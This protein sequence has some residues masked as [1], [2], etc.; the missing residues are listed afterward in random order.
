MK[1]KFHTAQS[2]HGKISRAIRPLHPCAAEYPHVG[3][4]SRER[5]KH[6]SWAGAISGGGRERPH[7]VCGPATTAVTGLSGA[8]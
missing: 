3:G 6:G 2:Q 8:T 1:P 5:D 7:R 4:Q